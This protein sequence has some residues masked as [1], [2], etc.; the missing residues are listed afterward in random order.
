LRKTALRA[1]DFNEKGVSDMIGRKRK[2][3]GKKQAE[4]TARK[5]GWFGR[6]EYPDPPRRFMR[7]TPVHDASESIVV[8]PAKRPPA[9]REEASPERI[10]EILDKRK[11]K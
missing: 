9:K 4:Q 5:H 1:P 7:E 6:K 10:I 3:R 11:R 2:G 8:M